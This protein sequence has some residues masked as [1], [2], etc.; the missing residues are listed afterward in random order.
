MRATLLILLTALLLT[1]PALA[2]AGND[3]LD[4]QVKKIYSA[5][6]QSSGLV[7]DIPIEAKVLDVSENNNWYKVKI[8]FKL[9]PFSYNYIGW[10]YIPVGDFVAERSKKNER[11]ARVPAEALPPAEQ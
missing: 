7:Y 10:A 6:D 4:L 2:Q 9:G 5:P 8:A 11:L 3:P 1:A